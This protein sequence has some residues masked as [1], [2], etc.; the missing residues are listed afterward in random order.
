MKKIVVA[1]N[2][3]DRITTAS[4]R[5]CMEIFGISGAQ[6]VSLVAERVNELVVVVFELAA[7]AGY[8]NL[9]YVAEALPVEIVK[10]LEQLGLGDDGTGTMRQIFQDAIFHGC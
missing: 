4:S 1:S 7:K 10:M 3:C 9:D 8:V 2:N 6:H 5:R